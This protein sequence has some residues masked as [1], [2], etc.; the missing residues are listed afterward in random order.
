MSQD[1][2]NDESSIDALK[3]TKAGKAAAVRCLQAFYYDVM[4]T[5]STAKIP[6]I[7]RSANM[8]LI[9]KPGK[10]LDDPTSYRPI[11]LLCCFY[12]LLEHLLLT[13]LAPVFERGSYHQSNL[14][15]GRT[16]VIRARTF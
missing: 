10:P 9:R 4:T 7:W 14:A 12:K 5:L 13:R 11:S 1:F 6:K 16:L 3:A 15:S 2:S 8:I